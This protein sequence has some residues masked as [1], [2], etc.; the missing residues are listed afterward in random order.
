MKHQL[1]I[2]ECYT[3]LL[4]VILYDLYINAYYYSLKFDLF[5]MLQV[6]EKHFKPEDIVSET[7]GYDS[8]RKITITVQLKNYRLK[9]EAVPSIFEDCSG[10]QHKHVSKKSSI[11]DNQE[12][13]NINSSAAT[14][15]RLVTEVYPLLFTLLSVFEFTL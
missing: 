12:R 8:K 1:H 7:S 15:K 11:K 6:C 5:L 13:D 4:N 10:K 14:S 2:Y 3:V 9:P